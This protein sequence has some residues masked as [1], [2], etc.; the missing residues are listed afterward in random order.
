MKA[1]IKEY[2]IS[3]PKDRV[4]DALTQLDLIA[5]WSGSEVEMNLSPGGDFSLWNGSVY[6]INLEVS[7]DRIVQ[8]WQE[9]SWDKP[10][11]VVFTL[12]A[13][14]NATVL[15]V[16]HNGIPDKSFQGVNLGW[17]EDYLKPLKNLVE[18][19]E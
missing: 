19:M 12:K 6:G 15:Q 18:S 14:G 13:K 9:E 1:L 5:A 16:L 7:P 11:K 17:D 10:S 3:A 4:Y 8:N 2:E